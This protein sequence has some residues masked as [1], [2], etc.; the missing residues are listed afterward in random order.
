MS[1][2][3]KE[4]NP[5]EESHVMWLK[6]IGEAMAKATNG[7]RVNLDAVVNDNPMG[8]T[9]TTMLDFAYVH[10]QLAMKYTAAVLN[11]DAFVPK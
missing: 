10:F 6:A 5:R 2:F 9:M 4:F 1:D 3:V 7:K 8:C 11:R